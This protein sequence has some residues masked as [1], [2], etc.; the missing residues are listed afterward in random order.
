M[1]ENIALSISSPCS[2]KWN[3]FTAASGGRF[4]G[5]CKKVVVDFTKMG[6]AEIVDF[7]R[8]K[9]T[10][11]C[12]RFRPN[13][14][15]VYPHTAVAKI[16]PGLTLF[17]AGFVSLLLLMMSKQASAQVPGIKTKTEAVAPCPDV[18][19]MARKA[20]KQ[21]IRG[22]V[23]SDE[24]HSP[25][26]GVNVYLKGSTEHTIT[27]VDGRFEFPREL[28]AGDVQ[29][30]NFIGLETQE[31]VIPGNATESLEV[32]MT[33]AYLELM[34]AIAVDETYVKEPSGLRKLWLA[35]KAIF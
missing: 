25:L 13:Q 15:K 33:P 30:F 28:N 16:N 10:H 3:D 20:V 5:S 18:P 27:D 24:D 23:K 35:I 11:T 8:A 12:G 22:V 1:K 2:E 26:P 32:S 34:G 31:H 14:L 19:A 29:V 4:C 6:D 9:P 21:I 7:F 17:K